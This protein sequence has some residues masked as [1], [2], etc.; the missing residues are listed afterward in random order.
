MS[1][2]NQGLIATGAALFTFA[3]SV[4]FNPAPAQ[5]V[6]SDQENPRPV[7]ISLTSFNLTPDALHLKAG[8]PILLRI[9]NDSGLAHDLT[10]PE[11]FRAAAMSP[12]DAERLVGGKIAVAPHQNVVVAMIP[13]AGRFQM[14]CSHAF[15]KMLG[16]SGTILVD[17]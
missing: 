5:V 11:F 3:A 13:R 9:A 2:D 10:A 14:K 4:A 17:S 8:Q 7:N 12:V 16:M 15:H 1:N 6:G